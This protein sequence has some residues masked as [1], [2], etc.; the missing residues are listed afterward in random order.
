MPAAQCEECP[1]QAA[2]KVQRLD[3]N[4]RPH[5]RML[6]TPCAR[7]LRFVLHAGHAVNNTIVYVKRPT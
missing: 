6:C 5:Y 3:A 1:S 4:L 2:R 7:R